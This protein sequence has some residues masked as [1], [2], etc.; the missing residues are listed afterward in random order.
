[1]DT[2]MNLVGQDNGYDFIRTTTLTPDG[3][4][5]TTT[6]SY[7][8]TNPY[9]TVS[10]LATEYTGTTSDDTMVA[11][12]GYDI[13][14]YGSNDGNTQGHDTIYNFNANG[15]HIQLLLVP[16]DTIDNYFTNHV[17]LVQNG[18]NTDITLVNNS[19]HITLIGVSATN[20]T[21]ADFCPIYT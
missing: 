12:S 5:V 18:A 7:S 15:D 16:G 17:S 10:H 20:I 4:N 3:Q 13:F 21:I 8:T 11:T 1:M 2:V 19:T 9:V 6:N 14:L